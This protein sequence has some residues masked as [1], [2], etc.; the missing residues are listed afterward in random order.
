MCVALKE[1]V[2]RMWCL[3]SDHTHL[4]TDIGWTSLTDLRD[5]PTNLG[6]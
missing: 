3:V 5:I 1:V 6:T 2:G 4:A